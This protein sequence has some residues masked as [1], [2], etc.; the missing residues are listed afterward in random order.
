MSATQID[1]ISWDTF[2]EK[3]TNLI[4]KEK[5]CLQWENGK[6]HRRME[7]KFFNNFLVRISKFF[8]ST[9]WKMN[10]KKSLEKLMKIFKKKVFTQKMFDFF[11]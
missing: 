4:F 8:S 6:V 7:I 9:G 10:F 3:K 5:L 11:S 2:D 1:G